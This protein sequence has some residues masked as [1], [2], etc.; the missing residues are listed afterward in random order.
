MSKLAWLLKS[1]TEL[2]RPKLLHTHFLFVL[3]TS[4]ELGRLRKP[5]QGIKIEAYFL[6]TN[7]TSCDLVF[8]AELLYCTPQKQKCWLSA[9]P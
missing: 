2:V 5:K 4:E 6:D 7:C 8:R 9:E 1:H 3:P